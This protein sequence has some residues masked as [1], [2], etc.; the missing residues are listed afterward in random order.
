MKSKKMCVLNIQWWGQN[1]NGVN[2]KL[3]FRLDSES[4]FHSAL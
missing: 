3:M 4:S 2:T 1:S